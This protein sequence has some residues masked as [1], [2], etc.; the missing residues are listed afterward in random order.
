MSL[1]NGG[2]GRLG[3]PSPVPSVPAE[4]FLWSGRR[5][6]SGPKGRPG[7][8]TRVERGPRMGPSPAT[9]SNGKACSEEGLCESAN[10]QMEGPLVPALYPDPAS[11]NARNQ[12]ELSVISMHLSGE[13]AEAIWP[14]QAAS[15]GRT[16]GPTGTPPS[17]FR[18][19]RWPSS[20]GSSPL[21]PSC[22]P[23]PVP[24]FSSEP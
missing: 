15:K 20:L 14:K 13:R 22:T 10:P 23:H 24:H 2:G 8:S 17:G 19:P 12:R 9:N 5:V 16:R 21:P 4:W 1:R 18:E 11:L 7:A 3:S 6:S